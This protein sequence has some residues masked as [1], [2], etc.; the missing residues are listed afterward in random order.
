MQVLKLEFL[1]F[2]IMEI[3]TYTHAYMRHSY[4]KY[5]GPAVFP[6]VVLQEGDVMKARTCLIVK[7]LKPRKGKHPLNTN[8]FASRNKQP[9]FHNFDVH[10]LLL[11]YRLTM[12]FLSGVSS[13]GKVLKCGLK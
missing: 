11:R 12:A 8:V 10:V 13:N 4:A 2:L 5:Q 9:N 6:L 7:S 3:R 1:K